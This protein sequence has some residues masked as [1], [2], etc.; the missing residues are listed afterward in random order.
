MSTAELTYQIENNF[1]IKDAASQ[2]KKLVTRKKEHKQSEDL[3]D[4]STDNSNENSLNSTN[5]S[6]RDYQELENSKLIDA[7]GPLIYDYSKRQDEETGYSTILKNHDISPSIR[8]KL[9]DWMFEV[10][11]A[12]QS[13][14]STIALTMHVLDCF[15]Y[16]SKNYTNSDLHLIGVTS[17]FIA[18]KAED[19][20]PF[21]MQIVKQKIAHNKFSEREIK[22]MEKTIIV[23]IDFKILYSSASDFI[24][25]YIYDFK[26]NNKGSISQLKM[27]KYVEDIEFIAVYLSKVI[28]H[29]DLFSS[30]KYSIRAIACIVASYDLIRSQVPEF[31]KEM[32]K[33]TKQWITFLI[34]QSEY[35]P[36]D[37]YKLYSKIIEYYSKFSEI[38]NIQHNLRNSCDLP[39][40][41]VY[42]L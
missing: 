24:R 28:L 38:T 8:T 26:F 21:N 9:I 33:F 10:L 29:S 27:M 20:I 25:T 6:Y 1:N 19:L 41:P 23:A 35:N 3:K 13:E 39:L 2:G 16:K 5:I 30:H 34:E 42:C 18:S 22:N 11:I 4:R 17:M 40:A 37:I 36:D 31:T 7:Y 15:L 14:E 32:E 12:Y